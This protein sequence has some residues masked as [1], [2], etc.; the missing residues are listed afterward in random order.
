VKMSSL[1]FLARD[2]WRPSEVLLE[3]RPLLCCR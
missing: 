3:T 1:S 2:C